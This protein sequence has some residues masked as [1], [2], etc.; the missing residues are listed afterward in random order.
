MCLHATEQG[1][2]LVRVTS[3]A[4]FTEDRDV[5]LERIKAGLM[6]GLPWY[7]ESRVGRGTRPEELL[8]GARSIICLGL[9]YYL[10]DEDQTPGPGPAGKVARYA[11]GRDYHNLMK[12][13]MRRYVGE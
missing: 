11:R 2:D 8:P 4:E 6:D 1:F 7:T 13:R 12:K 9:N 3:A 5:A 10:P